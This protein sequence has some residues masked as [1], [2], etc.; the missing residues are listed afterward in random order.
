MH[1]SLV[2]I[3]VAG[4]VTLVGVFGLLLLW[5]GRTNGSRWEISLGVWLFFAGWLLWIV[6]LAG[7]LH[8]LTAGL[9]LLGASLLA[10]LQRVLAAALSRFRS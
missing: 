4:T 6:G 9:C 3:A 10:G 8:P 7:A 1:L 5:I 2:L